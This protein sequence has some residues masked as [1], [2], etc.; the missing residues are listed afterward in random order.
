MA[1]FGLGFGLATL[2]FRR[3]RSDSGQ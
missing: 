3:S 2:L 1:A